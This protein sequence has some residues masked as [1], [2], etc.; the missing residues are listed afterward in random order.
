ME[1]VGDSDR[2]L[3]SPRRKEEEVEEGEGK[4]ETDAAAW[5]TLR[6]GVPDPRLDR[7]WLVDGEPRPCTR[8]FAA[9]PLTHSLTHSLVHAKAVCP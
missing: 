5:L 4:V 6:L 3:E 9:H 2:G 7:G 8:Q 1:D